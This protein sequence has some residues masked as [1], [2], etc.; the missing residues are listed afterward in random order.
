MAGARSRILRAVVLAT[1]IGVLAGIRGAEPSSA[2]S[3]T[4]PILVVVSS[5]SANPFG[6]YLGEVLRAEGINSFQIE[7][8]SDVNSTLLAA[9]PLVILTEM[10]LSSGQAT[11]FSSYVSGG[12][13]LIG[14]R[15]DPQLAAVFGL[16]TAAGTNSDGYVKVNPSHPAGA[17]I[18]TETLQFHGTADHYTL[19]GG[20]QVATL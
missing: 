19:A 12:G 17:G 4:S 3:A 1:V 20:T 8:L 6:R 15:P 5:A 13:T 2:A 9:F 11:M 14:L 18:A 7:A 16:A 10:P